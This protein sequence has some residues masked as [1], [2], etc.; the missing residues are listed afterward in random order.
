MPNFSENSL[1]KLAT[2]HLDLQVLMKEVV[3]FFDI[4]VLEG[5][6]D[7]KDQEADFAKGTTKLHYPFG[8]HNAIPSCAVDVAP[9]PVQWDKTGQFYYLAGF[10][11]ATARRLRD[12]KMISHDIRWGGDW[13]CN[14][15][16]NDEKGLRD[17]PHFELILVK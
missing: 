3:K 15:D 4:T 13:N 6:R 12:E 11:L 1:D 2:C 5:H 17:L 8:K 7:E 14:Y 9:Y 16:V 10:V